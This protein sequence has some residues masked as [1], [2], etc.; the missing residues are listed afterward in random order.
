[1]TI[2]YEVKIT[3]TA[4]DDADGERLAVAAMNAVCSNGTSTLEDHECVVNWV[5]SNYPIPNKQ[6]EDD[7]RHGD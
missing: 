7:E 5:G 3:Y 6:E 1:M 4:K 2:V